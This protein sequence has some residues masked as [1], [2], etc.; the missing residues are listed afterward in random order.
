MDLLQAFKDFV[1]KEK[2]FPAGD[3]LLLAVSGGVDSVVLCELCHRSGYA[4]VMA[5]GNFQLRGEESERDEQFVRQLAARYG[6]RLAVK[7]FET[8]DYA[9]AR[10]VSVQVAARELRYAWFRELIKPP[11]PSSI[12]TAHHQDDNIETLLINFFKGTGMAGLHGILPK[13]GALVRPL[14]FAD[15]EALNRFA[16]DNGLDWVEDRS[17]QTDTYTRNYFRHQLI[18]VVEKI[19][20]GAMGNL[21]DNILRFR[22]AEMLYRQ[23]L[24]QHKNN[25]LEIRGDEIHIPVLKLKKT[26]P[27]NTIVYEIIQQFGFSPRQVVEVVRLLDSGTGKAISSSTHRIL[28]NRN[29]L[30]ISAHRAATADLILIEAGQRMVE[31]AGGMLRLGAAAVAET[32]MDGSKT[33]ALLD[34]DMIQFPLLLRKWRKGDYFYPLGLRKKKKLGRFFI[35]NK[36]SLA[37]KE[38]AWVIEM[39]KKII[40]VVGYRIDDRFRVTAGTRTILKIETGMA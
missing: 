3:T 14:L 23:A 12:L 8:G 33:I 36:L 30:I 25:L 35:D 31:Y 22:E 15:K 38:R 39:D 37:D 21:A 4:F 9:A 26:V 28:K 7:R 16:L 32:G 27:L 20:P 17:N 34:A 18:P 5:H 2:L 40:W 19:H 24:Q 1:E 10:K 6:V 11:G 13:Q 29:W